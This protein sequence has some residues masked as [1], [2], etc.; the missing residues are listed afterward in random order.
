MRIITYPK[1]DAEKGIPYS[2]EHLRRLE[3]EGKFPKRIRLNPSDDRGMF[4]W[5]EDEIDAWLESRSQSVCGGKP[6]GWRLTGK[7]PAKR[8]DGSAASENEAA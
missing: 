4:G 3:A 2:R 7:Y 8:S 1:L 5:R 6:I